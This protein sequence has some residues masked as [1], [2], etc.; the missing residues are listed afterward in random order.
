MATFFLKIS[1]LFASLGTITTAWAETSSP[2]ESAIYRRCYQERVSLS[3]S[4]AEIPAPIRKPIKIIP[5]GC[6]RPF[7]YRGEIYSADPPQ[8]QDASTLRSFLK[9]VPEADA[10]LAEYQ[11]NRSKS[12][13]SAYTGTFGILILAFAGPISMAFDKNSRD[14]VRS[15]LRVAGGAIAVG[16][17]FY[18]FTLLRTNEYLLPKAVEKYNHA[19]PDDPIE[20]QFTAGWK[21]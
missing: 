12:K 7:L 1:L 10:V 14:S 8:A 20:L 21:F 2:N 6:E 5:L 17:F 13:L 3:Q 11:N 19:K 4:S 9:S 16:G 15:A 18:S